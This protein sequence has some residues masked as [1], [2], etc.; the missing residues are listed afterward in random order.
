MKTIT[1]FICEMCNQKLDV[2]KRAKFGKLCKECVAFG[3][4]VKR[5]IRRAKDEGIIPENG[6]YEDYI[7]ATGS[8]D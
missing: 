2:S 1:F 7:A 6:T 3:Y 4:K 5:S 8:I